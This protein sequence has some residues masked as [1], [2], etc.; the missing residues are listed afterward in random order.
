MRNTHG[1]VSFL[2]LAK[3]TLASYVGLSVVASTLVLLA[4]RNASPLGEAWW[5]IH[6]PLYLLQLIG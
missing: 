5:P 6:W 4:A 3:V 2:W 1:N